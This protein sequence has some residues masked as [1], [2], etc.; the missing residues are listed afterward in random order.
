MAAIRTAILGPHLRRG[1]D[2]GGASRVITPTVAQRR[3]VAPSSPAGVGQAPPA[4]ARGH[5]A[6]AHEREQEAAGAAARSAVAQRGDAEREHGREGDDV[7][8]GDDQQ[9]AHPALPLSTA[10]GATTRRAADAA[11][12]GPCVSRRDDRRRGGQARRHPERQGAHRRGGFSASGR[13]S[14]ASSPPRA[15]DI[16]RMPSANPRRSGGNPWNTETVAPTATSAPATPLAKSATPRPTGLVSRAPTTS[17]PP[18]AD[19]A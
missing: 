17:R 7:A 10:T 13:S 5:G 9:A 1:R 18:Q 4:D 2:R 3:C 11:T 16:W 15:T 8:D 14:A 12:S 19:P 6:E